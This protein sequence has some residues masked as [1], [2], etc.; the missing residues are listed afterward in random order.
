M[1]RVGSN[2][3]ERGYKRS[4]S[5]LRKGGP[6][7][8]AFFP[9]APSRRASSAWMLYRMFQDRWMVRHLALQ[10]LR[11]YG[12]FPDAPELRGNLRSSGCCLQQLLQLAVRMQFAVLLFAVDTC[13]VCCS[14]RS[15][16]GCA[17]STFAFQYAARAQASSQMLV[18]LRLAPTAPLAVSQK[19][20]IEG[21]APSGSYE[22]P[23]GS[24]VGTLAS[25]EIAD[26]ESVR[27]SK[28]RHRM[29]GAAPG[30][31]ESHFV[32][33]S[34][35]FEGSRRDNALDVR[36]N[37]SGNEREDVRVQLAA[38]WVAGDKSGVARRVPGSPVRMSLGGVGG[39]VR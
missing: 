13:A 5:R 4:S 14:R 24:V 37:V 39:V 32:F 33:P 9:D 6:S 35:C 7:V 26:V 16:P 19:Q 3:L 29:E 28:L 21:S 27:A 22:A 1:R 25:A 8:S 2:E 36:V 30:A 20:M 34:D 17:C 15:P 18:Y 12:L 38:E 31:A 23:L 11:M 10:S